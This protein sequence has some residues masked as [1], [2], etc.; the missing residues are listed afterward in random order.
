MK[1][2]LINHH[3]YSIPQFTYYEKFF[4]PIPV[5]SLAYLASTLCQ[6]GYEVRIVDDY[7]QRLGVA[8]ILS[9]IEDFNPALVGISC[10]TPLADEAFLLA[11]KIREKFP[12]IKIVMGHR[13]ADYFA[14][15]IVSQRIAD[16][17][18][19]G[20]GEITLLEI[21]KTLKHNGDLSAV[22]GITY[23]DGQ[24]PI[25][26][27]AR[28]F[29]ENLD[30]LPFPAWELFPLE[31]YKP[32]AEVSPGGKKHLP[33]L[34]S[35]GCP[36]SCIFCN[37]EIGNRFRTR[38]PQNVVSEILWAHEQFGADGFILFDANFPLNRESAIA[39][40][41]EMIKANLPSKIRWTTETRP[42]LIDEELVDLM[43]RA[44]CTKIQIGFESGSNRILS[45]LKKGFTI[46]DSI[47]AVRTIKKAGVNLYGLFMLGNPTETADEIKQT[48]R[49]AQSLDL[50]FAKFNL[51]V[52]YPGTP[53]YEDLTIKARLNANR[54]INFTSYPPSEDRVVY[55]PDGMSREEL[56][57]WQKKAFLKF[58]LRPKMVYKQ[59]MKIKHI[60]LKEYANGLTYIAKSIFELTFRRSSLGEC[61]AK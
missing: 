55:A 43:K 11:K 33:L 50:D 23:F 46:E 1:I 6:N 15:E 7:A 4:D 54:W 3:Y 32:C 20:E 47:R 53:A 2:L 30:L 16:I 51:F 10:L 45:V 39:L 61:Q 36:Y 25:K 56:I 29:I 49:F 24:K 40:C 19:H 28:S 13:H 41:N 35:R 31:R 58:Y 18:V 5:M 38:T 22:L 60:S 52:P 26:T 9:Y 57:N 59:L 34:T 21:V 44:G 8:G 14:G 17:V 48:I 12:T 42:D 27:P 37:Q